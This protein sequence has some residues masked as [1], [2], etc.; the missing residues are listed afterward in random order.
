MKPFPMPNP[1]NADRME[2]DLNHR[3]SSDFLLSQRLQAI[4]M[5]LIGI[6]VDQVC[7]VIS[8][9]RA[10]LRS[11]VHLWN[12]GGIDALARKRGQGRKPKISQGHMRV[13]SELVQHP[14]LINREYW[15]AK[16]LHCYLQEQFSLELG[17]STLTHSL[18]E[19]GF[20]RIVP[21]PESPERDA[22]QR[23]EFVDR[24]LP[25]LKDPLTEIWFGDE[26]GFLADPRPKARWAKKGTK[27]VCPKTGLHIRESVVGAA[28]PKTGEFVGLI[29]NAMDWE[30]FQVFL[31][32]LS[33]E[34]GRRRIVLVLDNAG[35][36]KKESLNWYNITP[37]YL[38][39]YS[40]DLNPIERLWGVIKDRFFANFYTKE[41]AKLIDRITEALL[42]YMD[43]RSA[44]KSICHVKAD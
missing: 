3:A 9:N 43:D 16:A 30:V 40:P 28:C 31:D 4:K 6:Q 35:W 20:R 39:P 11:W 2:I 12:E 23:G 42:Y 21:R 34:T 19:A 26:T 37:M 29:V 1:A 32:H 33:E 8:R 38:P 25:L 5:L 24:L 36:H 14:N 13:I 44:V 17:Y 18:R 10:T 41:R 7:E 27:P 15:T 22:Q